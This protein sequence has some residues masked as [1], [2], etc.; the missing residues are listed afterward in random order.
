MGSVLLL[1]VRHSNIVRLLIVGLEYISDD[2]EVVRVVKRRI[3]V[4]GTMS[5]DTWGWNWVI[6]QC[7][8]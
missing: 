3:A 8:R 2:F 7:L 6:L 5:D 4:V 1:E